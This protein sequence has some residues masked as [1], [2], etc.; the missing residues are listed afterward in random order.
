MA[1][2]N[3][4]EFTNIHPINDQA[5]LNCLQ[6]NLV[7]Y[8]R[9]INAPAEMKQPFNGEHGLTILANLFTAFNAC[10]EESKKINNPLAQNP[11]LQCFEAG[12]G[13]VGDIKNTFCLVSKYVTATGAMQPSTSKQIVDKF[14]GVGKQVGL[15]AGL[16]AEVRSLR[17]K[18]PRYSAMLDKANELGMAHSKASGCGTCGAKTTCHSD[19][20]PGTN[21]NK[22]S[23]TEILRTARGYIK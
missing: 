18:H 22:T 14:V 12:T 19:Q 13:F 10:L 4:L 9:R 2:Q 8:R 1:V 11:L 3:F 15:S 17:E 5:L 21:P 20:G 16:L 6:L 7:E 23:L